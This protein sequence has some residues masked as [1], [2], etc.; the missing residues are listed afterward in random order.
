MLRLPEKL[1]LERAMVNPR[2]ASPNPATADE[3]ASLQKIL[4]GSDEAFAKARS[5]V[6]LSEDS[7]A[8]DSIQQKLRALRSS[9][10]DAVT[11]RSEERR[12]GK[13]GNCGVAWAHLNER[14]K[15]G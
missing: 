14:N 8:L 1:N 4:Q 5:L 11:Q 2:L 9:A 15:I 12:V 6:Q 10:L 13:E 3:L 7:A